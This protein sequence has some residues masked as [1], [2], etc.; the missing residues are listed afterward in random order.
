MKRTNPIATTLILLFAVAGARAETV[1]AAVAS[2][3]A[4]TAGELGRRFSAD[5]G[6]EF[7][8]VPGS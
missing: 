2:N 7:E 6:H 3:F 8:L 4:D 1:R 5:S